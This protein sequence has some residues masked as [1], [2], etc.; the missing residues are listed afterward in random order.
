L[1]QGNVRWTGKGDL[2]PLLGTRLGVIARAY[3]ATT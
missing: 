1:M 2:V 3:N